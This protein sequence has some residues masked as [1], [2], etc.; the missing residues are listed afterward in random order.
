MIRSIVYFLASTLVT[1]P[2]LPIPQTELKVQVVKNVLE[3]VFGAMG[4]IAL[5]IIARAGFKYVTSQG[6][7]Q[8]IEK[9]K[10]TILYAIAGLVVSI[11]AFS[12]VNFV[13]QEVK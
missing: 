12:I 6:E 4:G 11:I 2:E 3:V 5:I 9:A 10:N 1:G 7:P 8:E 13:I